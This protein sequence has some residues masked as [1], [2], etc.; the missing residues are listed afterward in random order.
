MDLWSAFMF[1]VPR[2][3]RL[4][5]EAQGPD[6]PTTAPNTNLEQISDWLTRIIVGIGLTQ[7]PQISRFFEN[8]ANTWGPAFGPPPAGQLIAISITIHYLVMGFFQGFLLSSLWLPGALERAQGPGAGYDLISH[9]ESRLP[10]GSRSDDPSSR[11][12]AE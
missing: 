12:N 6:Q 7:L 1:G 4:D 2:Y 5:R 8:L 10:T 3:R 11:T 9:S